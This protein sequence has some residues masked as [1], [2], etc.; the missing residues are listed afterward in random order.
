[1]YKH[2]PHTPAHLFLDDTPYFI[3]GAIKFKR[4][5]LKRTDLKMTLLTE[6]RTYFDKYHWE[7]HHWVILDN[8]YHLLG[9]SHRG[10]DLTQIMRSV[11]SR[12]ARE[13][14]PAT[15]CRLP[16]WWNFWDYCPRNEADYYV[17]LNYLFNN[18]AKHGYVTDLNDYPF[19]SFHQTLEQEGRAALSAQFTNY[20]AY[21]TLILREAYDD[22]F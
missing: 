4:P 8:H 21:K 6:L 18:P 20:P 2:R 13:I 19:S 5:L 7:L 9:Q 10:E 3:T 14:K 22:D 15:D 16:V 1:M 11:H 12:T 17:R